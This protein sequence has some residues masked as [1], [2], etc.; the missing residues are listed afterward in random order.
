MA[1]CLVHLTGDT[2]A[3]AYPKRGDIRAIGPNDNDW[4]IFEDFR[5]WL[6][7]G[8]DPALFG[9]DPYCRN[10]LAV[11][12]VDGISYPNMRKLLRLGWPAAKF[13]WRINISE[14]TPPQQRDINTDRFVSLPL[15][16]FLDVSE[17]KLR[18]VVFDPESADGDGVARPPGT[19]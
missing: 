11:V 19:G 18:H 9:V 10:D 3:P 5:L 17:E 15:Q 6:A 4:P 1:E 7:A 13:A 16:K 12:R 2:R 14:L 8:R